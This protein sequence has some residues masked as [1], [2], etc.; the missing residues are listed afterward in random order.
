MFGFFNKATDPVCKMKADKNKAKYSSEYDGEKYYFC[1][2]DCKKSFEEE[3]K[4]YVQ[5]ENT[6]A[7]S[8]CQKNSKSCC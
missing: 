6:P 4:K 2:Q 8:C 3:P 1:S 5:Q 7:K